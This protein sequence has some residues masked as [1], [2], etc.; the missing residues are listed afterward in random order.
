MCASIYTECVY[1]LSPSFFPSLP[2]SLSTFSLPLPPPC[3]GNLDGIDPGLADALAANHHSPGSTIYS[4]PPDSASPYQQQP[5]LDV[6]QV[7]VACSLVGVVSTKSV[8]LESIMAVQNHVHIYVHFYT[9]FASK[10]FSF[11]WTKF[12]AFLR[13]L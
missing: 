12:C 4:D 8:I 9:L 13:I 6:L 7:G 10:I 1:S 11:F 2:P 5:T 3:A